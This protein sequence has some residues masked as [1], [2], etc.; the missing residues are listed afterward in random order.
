MVASFHTLQQCIP[1]SLFHKKQKNWYTRL[2]L[3]EQQSRQWILQMLSSITKIQ[4]VKI[5]EVGGSFSPTKNDHLIRQQC[6]RV[7][8]IKWPVRTN[9]IVTKDGQKPQAKKQS[10]FY[11][12]VE[13]R[14]ERI[15]KGFWM[16]WE[17]VN[18]DT[19]LI[20]VAY[21]VYGWWWWNW[22]KRRSQIPYP[23][24]GRGRSPSTIGWYHRPCSGLKMYSALLQT[25][26]SGHRLGCTPPNTYSSF[27]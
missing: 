10:L 19:L 4:D 13:D 21:T 2:R 1:W 17:W 16:T 3:H 14:R 8:T 23:N 27:L 22:M 9:Y 12:V 26:P 24:L 25:L 15:K 5:I 11:D 18:D 6:D 20:L 7:P